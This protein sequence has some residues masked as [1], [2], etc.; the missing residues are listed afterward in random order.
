MSLSSEQICRKQTGQ[1]LSNKVLIPNINLKRLLD[2]FINEGAF[3]CHHGN[4]L[5]VGQEA[6]DCTTCCVQ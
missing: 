5:F 4:S 2:D 6:W 1:P 3:A